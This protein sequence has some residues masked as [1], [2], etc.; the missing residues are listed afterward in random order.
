MR[1]MLKSGAPQTVHLG[2]FVAAMPS[3]VVSNNRWSAKR[4]VCSVATPPL[5]FS[6]RDADIPEYRSFIYPLAR[7]E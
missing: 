5:S 4:Y 1:V 7:A 6:F 3:S 2:S